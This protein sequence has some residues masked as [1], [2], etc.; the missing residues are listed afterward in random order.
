M[1]FSKTPK[2]ATPA[3]PAV[4]STPAAARSH[5]RKSKAPAPRNP[6]RSRTISHEQ[7]ERRA[8]E[9]YASRGYALRRP[10]RRLAGSR[11]PTPRAG[12]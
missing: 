3:T 7:I 1:A 4:T 2:R 8:Y 12:L 5:V 6:P 11:T 9:I 10:Q